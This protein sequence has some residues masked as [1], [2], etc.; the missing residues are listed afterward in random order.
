MS[1]LKGILEHC[2]S[3]QTAYG[4]HTKPIIKPVYDFLCNTLE[5]KPDRTFIAQ[6]ELISI[7]LSHRTWTACGFLIFT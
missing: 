4:Q 7:S 1:R 3:L 5:A 2:S 6:D